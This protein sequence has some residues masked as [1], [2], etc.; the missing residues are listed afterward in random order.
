[1]RTKN[2]ASQKSRLG[3]GWQ[4]E[5]LLS[6]A[7][8]RVLL[9][10]YSLPDRGWLGMTPLRKHILICGCPRSGSTMLL[11][12]MDAALPRARKFKTEIRG[13]RAATSRWRNHEVMLTKRPRDMFDLEQIKQFYSQRETELKIIITVRDPRD[14]LTS[15]HRRTA[16]SRNYHISTSTWQHELYPCI[17]ERLSDPDVMVMRY[18]TLVGSIDEAERQLQ[19]FV[20]EPFAQSLADFHQTVSGSFDTRPL[21]GIRPVDN[22][23]VGR[24][25][26][27]EFKDRIA[28]ILRDIPDFPQQLIS[29]GYESDT[30]WLNDVERNAA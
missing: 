22:S 7:F 24:W 11:L 26:D 21:N 18:E 2:K 10:C 30:Q 29:L 4:Y 20:N 19:N 3:N 9:Q 8:R 12:M 27:P 17:A 15:R 13:F 1:M 14:A 5:S 28:E 25:R 23:G 6:Q 16:S